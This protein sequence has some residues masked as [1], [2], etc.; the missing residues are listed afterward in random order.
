[1][2]NQTNNLICDVL[3]NLATFIYWIN[4]YIESNKFHIC[5][6]GLCTLGDLKYGWWF[7]KIFI[8]KGNTFINDFYADY[9]VNFVKFLINKF[10]KIKYY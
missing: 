1:M 3:R 6:K 8:E 9:L 10:F 5:K 7:K 4:L 2:N